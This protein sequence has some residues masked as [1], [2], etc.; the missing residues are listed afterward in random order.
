MKSPIVNTILLTFFLFH[1]YSADENV[2]EIIVIDKEVPVKNGEIEREIVPQEIYQRKPLDIEIETFWDN[3]ITIGIFKDVG[4]V[5]QPRL[6]SFEE[7]HNFR[8]F[9]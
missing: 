3:R 2:R 9:Q 4:C 1:D 8:Y 5:I 6:S 7:N